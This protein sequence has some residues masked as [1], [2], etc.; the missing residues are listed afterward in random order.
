MA[1][2]KPRG[3]SRREPASGAGA[4]QSWYGNFKQRIDKLFGAPKQ[5]D[6]VYDD[7]WMD[8]D[9]CVVSPPFSVQHNIHVDFNSDSGFTGLPKEWEALLNASGIAKEEVLANANEVLSCLET[10]SN[11][12]SEKPKPI[13][14]TE[15]PD[16]IV[17]SL[18][19]LISKEDPS[20]LYSD[21]SKIGEGAAGEVFVATNK[22][23]KKK[24]AI[25]QMALS[26]QN[27]KMLI[28]EIA[29]MKDS[30]HPA[31]VAYYDSYVVEDK[32]WVVM[33]LMSGGCLTDVLE[34]YDTVKL[35]EGQIAFSCLQ[36]LA[37]LSYIH[38]KHRIHRDIKSDNILIGE[39]GAVKIADF[40]Y[41][42][43]LSKSRAK[44]QTIVG[45]PY[46]MA[47]ELIRGTEYDQKVDIWSLGI[48]LMEM[49]EGEPPYMSFPPLRALFLITT[50]GI[51]PLKEPEKWSPELK[52][53][54]S[55]CITQDPR[56]RPDANTLLVHP[57]LDKAS[58]SSEMLEAVKRSRKAK[59]D[60]LKLLL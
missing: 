43:Q 3:G 21:I 20:N 13:P 60:A 15:A 40:G 9:S 34:Q 54:L 33:E 23:T 18:N 29:I 52:D 48:M 19:D 45:T 6:N 26:A 35:S 12:L 11:F 27:M 51:P 36:V 4:R 1:D 25:K 5:E 39:E 46:W 56:A 32:I 10:Q 50:K 17:C 58:P 8:D 59:E 2:K 28:T 49:L 30:T 53:F 7:S 44:R 16:D 22:E 42:A 14:Q 24:V 38:S 55:K 31:I 57:F 37:G 41:A 47:P